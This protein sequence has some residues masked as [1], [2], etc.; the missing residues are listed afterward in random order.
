MTAKSTKK[1]LALSLISLV[2]CV[3]MLVGTTF[4]WFTDSVTSA[5]NIIRS[6]NLDVELEYST[7]LTNW[8]TV[9]SSTNVFKDGALWEPGYTEVVYLRVSNHGSLALKY[10]LGVNIV[11]EKKGVN[12]A[13]ETFK[14]SD[15]IMYGV[16][17]VDAA[18]T[19][20]AAAVTAVTDVSTVLSESFNTKGTLLAKTAGEADYPADTL[21]MV[22]YMPETVGNEANHDGNTV[23]EINLGIKLV[24]TQYTVEEDSFDELYDENAIHYDVRVSTADEL[25][26]AVAN[27]GK[28]TVI[29]IDGNVVLNKALSKAGLDSI[30][31]V[32]F[33]DDATLDQATYNM[34][35]SGAKV[36]FEGL[37][38]THGEKAYGNGGQTSTAFA[39]WEANEVSYVDCTFNRSVGTIHAAKHSFI[40]CTFN[41]VDNPGNTKSEYPLYIC[42]GKDYEVTDC[43][44][45]CTNRGAILFY[46]DGG[47]GVDT[48]NI[49]NTKFL[50]DIIDD[51]T[52]VEIHNN[53]TT[54]VYNVNIKNATVG[55]GIVN[56]LYRIKP[57]NKGEVNVTVD[58]LTK[59][60]QVSDQT[61]L[62]AALSAGNKNIILDAGNYSLPTLS[63]KN[64]I[65]IDGAEG[66]TIVGDNNTGFGGNF[67]SDNT[68]NNLDFTANTNGVRYSY[69]QG[70]T[71]TFNNCTFAG[72]STYGFHID[73]SG[74]ATFIFNNCTFSGFNAFAGDLQK[75]EFNNCTF[76]NNGNYGH[77]NIW[78]TAYLKDCT[79]GDKTSIGTRGDN[80]HIFFNGVEESYHHEYIGSADSL[81][82]FAQSVAGGDKWKGQKVSLVNDIDLAGKTWPENNGFA[83]TFDGQGYS[84]KNLTIDGGSAVAFFSTVS[85]TAVIENIV[86][87]NANVSGEHY[88]GVIVGWEGNE[89]A[90]A[91][92]RNCTVVNSTIT[93]DTDAANDNGDKVGGICGYAV[94]LNITGC[95]VKDTTIKGYRDMGGI[96]GYANSAKVT[97]KDNTVE[98]VTLVIDNDVNYKNYTTDAEHDANPVVGEAATGANVS[99]NTVK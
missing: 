69:A 51:K 60:A 31:F 43:V 30:K 78:S 65:T 74:G 46:N 86:F 39:V 92:I 98:N 93:C 68:F 96:L 85:T 2:V 37:T 10:Q 99:N 18:Y 42:D 12:Q 35:F 14:L 49:T 15:S 81:V 75:I 33:S 41:G 97:V 87:D 1:A 13:G 73:E 89:T 24:A 61:E 26:N 47:N 25:Y 34:H 62:T 82:A 29:A 38:L 57:A 11:S 45:N 59:A 94:T 90:P 72:D 52:A 71:T 91:T 83:G 77:T 70:G 20:R 32:A 54:Q 4:A 55:D 79:F 95:T 53:S 48:L 80:A 5:N 28:D 44:F 76:L 22:V 27:A 9:T 40:G 88:V 16:E 3:S 67:G 64:G 19:D 58:G 23:P 21:A 17:G 63:G 36:T 56:G 84:I 6:G 50:G 66:A 8:N 7:D